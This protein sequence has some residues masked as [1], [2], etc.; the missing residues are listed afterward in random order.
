MDELAAAEAVL[1]MDTKSNA[2]EEDE[3][4]AASD[5]QHAREDHP[6]ANA[7]SA[8]ETA[9]ENEDPESEGAEA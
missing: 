4:E 6:G 3:Q 8:L 2:E 7:A 5:K 1:A 9:K